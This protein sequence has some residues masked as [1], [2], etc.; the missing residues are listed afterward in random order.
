VVT[1]LKMPGHDRHRAGRADREI[2]D[3]LPTIVM[4]AFGTIETAVEAMKRGA[5]DYVTKPFEGDELII[6]IK[7]GPRARG[8][9][10]RERGAPAA[11]TP[12]GAAPVARRGLDRLIGDSPA[13]RR[14]R[15][16]SRR[17]RRARAAC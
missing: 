7:R 11:S 9:G 3:A 4:T 2:D 1:D 12:G 13:M 15:R 8:D 5:F 10:A 17:S 16:R 6:A 14:S